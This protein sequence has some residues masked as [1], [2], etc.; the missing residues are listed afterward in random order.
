METISGHSHTAR[1]VVSV[2]VA[3]CMWGS[4]GIF[5]RVLD[6]LGYSPL[7]IVFSRMVIAVAFLAAFFVIAR[8]TE[9]FKIK[10]RDIWCIAGAG[11][12]SA[13]VL[14]LFYSLSTVMNSLSLASVLLAT[15]P[16]FVVL[17]S[18]RAFGERITS[19][20]VRSLIIV[21]AGCVLT[22]GLIS[23]GTTGA[24]GGAWFSPLGFGI[25]LLAA[26]GWAL[27]GVMT[28]FALNKG[29]HPLTVTIYA[30][31]IGSLVCAP[32]TDFGVIG[33]SVA[34]APA[35]MIV[36]LILHTLFTSLLPYALFTYGM[37]YMD[38]GKA[39]IIASVEPVVATVIGLF[40]Y[41]E[42]PGI[43]V[44]SGI[45]LALLGIALMNRPS[46]PPPDA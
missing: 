28:R 11:I 8:R 1:G 17:I 4:V 38:T 41:D 44:I 7:T 21:F 15:A 46:A 42:K 6:G 32:F 20:K 29:Y 13:I 33:A 12:S 39:A 5:V 9:L 43:I 19:V 18:A 26:V 40:V 31:L 23:D 30:F 37:K 14:N 22:S 34:D 27:Y 2:L 25:G 16:I 45:V 36:F 3:G 35:K 10:L 24:P